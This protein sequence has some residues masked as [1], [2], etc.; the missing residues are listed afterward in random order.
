[1]RLLLVITCSL[2]SHF[3][4]AQFITFKKFEEGSYVL[5]DSRTVRHA[6]QIKLQSG[7]KLVIKNPDGTTVKLK[8]QELYSFRIGQREYSTA[9][10]F[11][12]QGGFGINV[13][14]AFVEQLDSGQV[15]LMSY[16]YT[17]GNPMMGAGGTMAGG[18]TSTMSAFLLHRPTE[19]LYVPVQPGFYTSAG[20]NRFR[21]AVRP[22]LVSRPDLVKLLDEKHITMDNLPAVIRALNAGKPYR[23]PLSHYEIMKQQALAKQAKK[24]AAADSARH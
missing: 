19:D 21:D 17:V 4:Q 10:N 7:S 3:C 22:F 2:L 13:D 20:G 6:G 11:H 1:M 14:E 9:R 18:G 15:V 23:L 24:A 12:V 5:T 8:P 16:E